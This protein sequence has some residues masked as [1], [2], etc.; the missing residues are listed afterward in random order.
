MFNNVAYEII[1]D[2][3][4]RIND[5]A[6]GAEIIYDLYLEALGVGTDDD[7]VAEAEAIAASLEGVD[8]FEDED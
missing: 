2:A 3:T 4:T 5:D 1:T 7:V 6:P 8:L